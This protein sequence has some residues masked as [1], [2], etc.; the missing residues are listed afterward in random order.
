MTKGFPLEDLLIYSRTNTKEKY[1]ILET[2]LRSVWANPEMF[3]LRQFEID[4]EM[5]G[6]SLTKPHFAARRLSLRDTYDD[7]IM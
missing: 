7:N 2:K 4:E 6:P 3:Q 1:C 5:F